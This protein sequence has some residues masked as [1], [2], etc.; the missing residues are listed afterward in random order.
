MQ[1]SIKQDRK[2]LIENC[3]AS[4]LMQAASYILPFISFPYLSRVLGVEKFGLVFWA[5]AFMQYFIIF[6][7][8]GFNMSSVR[9]V[10]VCKDDTEEISAIFNSVMTAKIALTVISFFILTAI[11]FAVPKFRSDIVLFYLTFFMV[12][13]NT[14]YPAWFFQGIARMKYMTFLNVTTKVIFLVLIFAFVKKESDYIYVAVLNSLG[15]MISGFLGVYFAVRRF[16]VRL[17]I[18]TLN[19]IIRQF[20]VAFPFFVSRFSESMFQTTSSFCLGLISN[21][22]TVGYYIAAEKI[23]TGVNSLQGPVITPIYP[24]MAKTRDIKL[25]KKIL[26]ITVLILIFVSIGLWMFAPQIIKI[27]YGEQMMPAYKTLRI[28]SITLFFAVICGITRYPFVG[29]LGHTKIIN[30]SATVAAVIHLIIFFILYKTGSLNITTIAYMTILPEIIVL[31][32]TFYTIRKY[33]LL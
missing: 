1:E 28:F 7:T 24:Y 2:A 16:H 6:T 23:Y 25:F 11:I 10:A 29:A 20:K 18:P 33:K 31:S 9:E 17:Y 19:R 12:I 15:F 26:Y 3:I 14:V 4:V 32:F 30:Y 27:F 13:G 8:F 5:Q 22:A 21:P